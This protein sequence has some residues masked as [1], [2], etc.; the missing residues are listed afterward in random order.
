MSTFNRIV[1]LLVCRDIQAAHDFLVK[2]FG[3]K[4][5][6]VRRNGDGQPFH[7]EVSAG[8]TTIWLHRATAEDNAHSPR[9]GNEWNSGL[10]LHVDNVDEHWEHARAA[11]AQI[12][13][14]PTDQ[15]YGQREYQVRD[16]EGHLW[17]FATPVK[18]Q[19]NSL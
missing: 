4:A 2:A 15:P 6:G 19:E 13:T 7:G 17:W 16:P 12:D 5:G 10:C 14:K 1:P 18:V 3:F 11:G 8:D 9:A